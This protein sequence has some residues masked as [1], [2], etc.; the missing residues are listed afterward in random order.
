[1][2]LVGYPKLLTVTVIRSN[3]FEGSGS[4]SEV[5]DLSVKR[6]KS[7]LSE[8]E[9]A[10]EMVRRV[11]FALIA[12]F[13]VYP[14]PVSSSWLRG[15]L[16]CPGMLEGSSL[17][18]QILPHSNLGRLDGACEKIGLIGVALMYFLT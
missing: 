10:G 17:A 12:V 8:K 4:F 6:L 11:T 18:P 13:A 3:L 5:S 7:R 1:M 14:F 16:K 9:T 2:T 15:R